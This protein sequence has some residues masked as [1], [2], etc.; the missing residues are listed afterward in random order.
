MICIYLMKA[1]KNMGYGKY[2][3]YS[4]GVWNQ[5]NHACVTDFNTGLWCSDKIF[6][7]Y[8][9]YGKYGSIHL[10]V[11]NF[12]SIYT[13]WKLWQISFLVLVSETNTTVLVVPLLNIWPQFYKMC[14]LN[15][16]SEYEHID[17]LYKGVLYCIV[18]L[19]DLAIPSCWCDWINIK[20]K[21]I[22][23]FWG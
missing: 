22:Y 14:H 5:L 4:I 17:Q 13:P 2:L 23:I 15:S 19:E 7:L 11:S 21:N 9:F 8:T 6:S 3:S 12:W 18:S 10:L 20:V 1:V 16:I